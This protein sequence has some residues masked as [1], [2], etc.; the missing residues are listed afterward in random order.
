MIKKDHG[1]I[2][3]DVFNLRW[4]LFKL[5]DS[6]ICDFFCYL[7][8]YTRASNVIRHGVRCFVLFNPTEATSCI[9]IYS[10]IFE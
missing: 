2:G 8:G 4:R 10:S 5:R 9:T 1:E 3:H 7:I 6:E